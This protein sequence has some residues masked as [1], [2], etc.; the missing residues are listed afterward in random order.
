MEVL[1][2]IQFSTMA[3]SCLKSSGKMTVKEKPVRMWKGFGD[4]RR[5]KAADDVIGRDRILIKL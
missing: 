3:L 2:T 4:L 5:V 1:P